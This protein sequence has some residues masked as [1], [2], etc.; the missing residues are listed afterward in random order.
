MMLLTLSYTSCK[1]R[2][3]P[4]LQRHV[5]RVNVALRRRRSAWSDAG[6]PRVVDVTLAQDP[7]HAVL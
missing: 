7:A 1:V 6:D 5:N 3:L 2:P 4:N